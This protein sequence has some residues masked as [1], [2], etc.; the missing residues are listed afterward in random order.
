MEKELIINSS[1]T[2][3]EIALLE[4]SKLVE[5][6]RQK[7]DNNFAVGDIFL[8]RIKKLMPGLNAAFVDIGHRKDAFLHFTDIG[9]QILSLKKYTN[10]VIDKKLNTS[11]LE[12][13]NAEP[14]NPKTGKIDQVLK[15]NDAILVQMLKE[16]IS[17]KGPRLTCDI[18]LPGRFIVITP[19]SRAMAVSK[20]IT[21][22]EERKRLK[23]LLESI[24]PK[25]FGIIVRTAAT[26][27]KVAD[28]HGE[29][30]S[31]EEK[32][33]KI[34]Q[35]LKVTKEPKKLL[36]EI[37]KTSSLLRDI[38][39]ENFNRV[40]VDNKDL[41]K[42]LKT[43][44]SDIAPEK[45]N[46]IKEYRGNKPI[47]D[48]HGITKQIKSSFGKTSTMNS[49]AYIVVEGTEAMH[50]IDVNSGPKMQKKNQE[51]AA[52][53]VNLEAAKEIARQLRLRDM[54]G[55]IIIDY[56]DMRSSDN[57]SKLFRSMKEFMKEDRA[58]HTI[59]PLSKFGLMQI[60]RQRARP[61]VKIDTSEVCPTC[62]GTGKAKPTILITDDLERDLDYIVRSRPKS[63][64]KLLVHPYVF[65]YL[66]KGFPSRQM[67]WMGKYS[68][69]I[70]IKEDTSLAIHD[71]KFYDGRDDEIRM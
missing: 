18:T 10:M 41:Y 15:K 47:F 67:K 7:M 36:S 9:P 63:K 12:H 66:K 16:P 28:L 29:I 68:K 17:T 3:V 60:T 45:V 42:S 52:I 44:I 37:D 46:I 5:I 26:G 62:T 55:L 50:V 20:K 4:Q 8:G 22:Q 43:Y 53:A 24:R 48:T 38:L 51:D 35:E 49:G 57:K 61:E 54:G 21:D 70:N 1:P 23:V 58:Q 14:D 6:H 34:Y 71:Y 32:W 2:E 64:I 30:R 59:L 33:D 40:I 19:F 13:F 65:T 25:K 11:S 31:L 69:W 56:I 27:K 39:S